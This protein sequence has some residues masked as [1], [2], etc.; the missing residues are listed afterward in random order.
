MVSMSGATG[1]SPDALIIDRFGLNSDFIEAQGLSWT[2][3]L[4]TSS[5]ED[6]A[7]SKHN[8]HRKPYVQ[9][10][11]QRFGVRKVEANALVVRPEA[12][13]QLCL[14]TVRRYIPDDLLSDFETQREAAQ[15][16]ARTVVAQLLDRV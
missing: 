9:D 6:L 7:N 5:G 1:Y 12:G 14:D 8:D 15:Q 2:N 4:I 11:I 10:Y 13:R 3:N 16:Q